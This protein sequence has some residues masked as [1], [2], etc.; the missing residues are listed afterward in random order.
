MSIRYRKI[1]VINPHDLNILNHLDVF[2]YL[3]KINYEYSLSKINYR[4]NFHKIV[5]FYYEEVNW[6]WRLI[7]VSG[8]KSVFNILFQKKYLWI[9]ILTLYT[10][11]LIHNIIKFLWWIWLMILVWCLNTLKNRKR[12]FPIRSKWPY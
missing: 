12:N 3:K 1:G 9:D 6:A 7:S 5:F 4:K 8:S 11:K 10:D 2:Q